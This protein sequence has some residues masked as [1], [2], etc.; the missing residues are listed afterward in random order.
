MFIIKLK[1]ERQDTTKKSCTKWNGKRVKK[2]TIA[3]W[4]ERISMPTNDGPFHSFAVANSC[5]PLIRFSYSLHFQNSS[6]SSSYHSVTITRTRDIFC[7]C[8]DAV[9]DDKRFEVD[10][11]WLPISKLPIRLKGKEARAWWWHLRTNRRICQR[12]FR[13]H[14]NYL[15]VSKCWFHTC[16]FSS[17]KIYY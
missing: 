10:G 1:L 16:C 15:F 7:G 14:Q 8:I 6:S 9:D 11:W 4:N 17:S 12:E 13:I 2:K 5:I 3:E